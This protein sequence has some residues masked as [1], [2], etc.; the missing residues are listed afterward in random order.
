[1]DLKKK[2]NFIINTSKNYLNQHQKKYWPFK[3]TIE[4]LNKETKSQDSLSWFFLPHIATLPNLIS[5]FANESLFTSYSL[6]NWLGSSFFCQVFLLSSDV[7]YINLQFCN[8]NLYF[9]LAFVEKVSDCNNN[10]T[11]DVILAF[12][13]LR[14]PKPHIP[15]LQ[16]ISWA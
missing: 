14:T 6:R 4:F 10:V 9:K 2:K 13:L 11:E 16:G 1:M 8:G 15:D 12:G 3:I 7:F 5:F